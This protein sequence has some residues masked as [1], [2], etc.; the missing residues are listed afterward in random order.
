MRITFQVQDF[1]RTIW[2]GSRAHDYE[3]RLEC[4]AEMVRARIKNDEQHSG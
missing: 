2:A 1:P 3:A 4:S